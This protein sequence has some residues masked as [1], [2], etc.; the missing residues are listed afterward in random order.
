MFRQPAS[1]PTQA[2]KPILVAAIDESLLAGCACAIIDDWL[3]HNPVTA[4]HVT[5]PLADFFHHP[6]ELM[7]KRYG[8]LFAG[9]G[10]RAGGYE[11]RPAEVLVEI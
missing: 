9:D 8:D 4:L 11:V 7:A 10:M 6:A 2:H 1:P 3:H 5:H